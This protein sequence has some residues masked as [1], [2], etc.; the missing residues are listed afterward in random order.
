MKATIRGA[1]EAAKRAQ[2]RVGGRGWSRS[3][4]RVSLACSSR[5]TRA[6]RALHHHTWSRSATEFIWCIHMAPCLVTPSQSNVTRTGGSA[7]A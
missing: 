1:R 5:K 6:R 3:L 4:S 2:E 7:R